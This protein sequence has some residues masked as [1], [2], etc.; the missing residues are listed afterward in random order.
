MHDSDEWTAS[1]NR[2]ALRA[3]HEHEHEPRAPDPGGDGQSEFDEDRHATGDD[4]IAARA[5][6]HILQTA[7]RPHVKT[8]SAVPQPVLNHILGYILGTDAVA[9][10]P[11]RTDGHEE[12][13]T[14]NNGLAL[15][16]HERGQGLRTRWQEDQDGPPAT[17]N[18]QPRTMGWHY[19]PNTSTDAIKDYGRG[20]RTTRTDRR[21]RRTANLEQ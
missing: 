9:G 7:L 3:R 15:H 17:K 6:E 18:S 19:E 16:E 4:N 5:F 1:N 10:R 11:A 12:Q 14:S 13:L 2:L 8:S 20:D 21:P